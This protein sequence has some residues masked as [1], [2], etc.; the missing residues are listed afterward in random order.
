MVVSHC[1]M[2]SS[3]LAIV[4][5]IHAR[6]TAAI[7]NLVVLGVDTRCFASLSSK[8]ASV[9]IVGVDHRCKK[10]EAR[11]ESENSSHWADGVAPCSAVLPCEEAHN[12]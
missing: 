5:A 12:Y 11:E 8:S 7:I 10:T 6:N 2:H 1:I 4:N 3:L 9:A